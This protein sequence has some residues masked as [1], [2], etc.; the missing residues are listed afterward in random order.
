MLY[1]IIS[2][3]IGEVFVVNNKIGVVIVKGFIDREKMKEYILS[4]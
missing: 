1:K 4:I 3:N 2:G